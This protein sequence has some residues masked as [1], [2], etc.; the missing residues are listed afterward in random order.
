[1]PVAKGKIEIDRERCKGCGLCIS[2][3]PKQR[4]ATSAGL[5]Q[6]GYY[7]AEFTAAEGKDGCTG[8]TLCAVMCPDLAI[9][10][11]RD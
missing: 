6:K 5:N 2:V 3:C 4:I 9:E 10:V 1:M 7:P 8:C 11:Y